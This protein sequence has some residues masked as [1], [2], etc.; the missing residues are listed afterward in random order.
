MSRLLNALLIPA[1]LWPVTVLAQRAPPEKPAPPRLQWH[2]RDTT[3]AEVWRF[4]EPKAGG[5]NPDYWFL[6]NRLFVGADLRARRWEVHAGV[7]YVQFGWLPAASIG[8]GPLGTGP[9][10]FDHAGRTDSRQLYVS[11]LNVKVQNVGA[12]GVSLQLGRMGYASG[13]E[14]ASGDPKIETIKRQRLDSRLIGE[15]EWS[16]YQRA[17]DGA[18]LDVDRPEW[19]ATGAYFQPTQGGFEDR[20]GAFLKH[21]HIAAATIN[22]KPGQSRRHTDLQGFVY[23]YDDT[24]VVTTRPDNQFVS[25]TK[26]DVHIS[27]AGGSLVGAYPLGTRAQVDILGWF[28]GQSGHWYGQTHRAGAAAVE[29]GYQRTKAPWR[30][31]IRAGWFRSTGDSDPSDARHQTFFQMIPTAR[32]YSLSTVYNLMNLSELFGQV[33]LRPHA[34]LNLRLD[35]H[36]L[37]LSSPADLWYAGS[38]ATQAGGT[39]FG[40]AGRRSNGSTDLG[41][42]AEGALDWAASTHLSVNGYLGAMHG[43]HVVSGTFA[44]SRLEFGYV[45]TV[46]SF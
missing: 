28:A 33:L 40:F 21:V 23:R 18:R 8:P 35:V 20:A 4:F 7:Q 44:G 5:G 29:L 27:S 39:T 10:Y 45:E 36:H 34:H 22:L 41:A 16:L 12:S 6:A 25:A 26:A 14:S 42:M 19:H 1:M 31:W 11:F 9:Q 17:F 15:F 32:R 46:V 37:R 2:L 3:R 24:R 43:G 30:P 38:G 13:A